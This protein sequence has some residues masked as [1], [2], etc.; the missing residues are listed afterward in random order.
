MFRSFG[1]DIDNVVWEFDRFAQGEHPCFSGRNNTPLV[2]FDGSKNCKD[3]RFK[4]TSQRGFFVRPTDEMNE[5]VFVTGSTDRV[6]NDEVNMI[7]DEEHTVIRDH[8]DIYQTLI[9]GCKKYGA[10][11]ISED[12]Q[13]WKASPKHAQT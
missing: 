5:A 9:E 8:L 12:Y 6:P 11:A 10:M 13:S 3:M 2:K 1:A 4:D 7:D